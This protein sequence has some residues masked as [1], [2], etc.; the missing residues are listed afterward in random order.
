M[1][2][3]KIDTINKI[4]KALGI[5]YSDEQRK[6]LEQPSNEAML[7]N[8]CAGSGKTTLFITNVLV[9]EIT[10]EQPADSV[11]GITFSRKAREEMEERY[12]KYVKI[13]SKEGLSVTS[14]P[15]FQ[16]F[17]ALFL[18]LLR[19]LPK[20]NMVKVLSSWS[21]YYIELAKSF[22]IDN[23]QTDKTK[24][25]YLDDIFNTY[26]FLINQGFS[27]DGIN[28]NYSLPYIKAIAPDKSY[29]LKKVLPLIDTKQYDDHYIDNYIKVINK[30]QQLKHTDGVIDFND[31]MILLLNELRD[32][33]SYNSLRANMAKYHKCYIDE[34]QDIDALQWI[35]IKN[36]LSEEAM[37]KIF[38][39]GDDDQS[40]YGFRGSS[41]YYITKFATK[42]VPTAKVMNLSTNYRT[43][44][45]ILN[46]AVPMIT[47]NK[48]RLNKSLDA[49]NKDI[50]KISMLE[51]EGD[52]IENPF[53]E[54]ILETIEKAKENHKNIAIL[55][56]Y[57]FDKM[58]I[59]DY[60]ATKEIYVKSSTGLLQDNR[61]YQ[62]I[63]GLM[64]A[65]INNDTVAFIKLSN[66]IG[67]S[68]LK[69]F[70]WSMYYQDPLQGNEGLKDFLDYALEYINKNSTNKK[71]IV[72]RINIE[73][74]LDAIEVCNDERDDYINNH[75]SSEIPKEKQSE[76][77]SLWDCVYAI[78][79]NYYRYMIENNYINGAN[80]NELVAYIEYLS[81]RITT[82]K[83]FTL[84]EQSKINNLKNKNYH[85][86]NISLLTIHQAKGLEFNDVFLYGFTEGD[87]DDAI[88]KLSNTF[89]TNITFT[90]F[91]KEFNAL[92]EQKKLVLLHYLAIM[93]NTDVTLADKTLQAMCPDIKLGKLIKALVKDNYEKQFI[94]KAKV[95]YEVFPLENRDYRILYH[96]LTSLCNAVE[97]ERRILYVSITRAK[98]N[99]YIEYRDDSASPLLK[100][101]KVTMPKKTRKISKA[102]VSE[103]TI[104]SGEAEEAMKE[105]L[106]L[107]YEN[108]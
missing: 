74:I 104:S 50:G 36:L 8:A 71:L 101:L 14:V 34:F 38:V 54:K 55:C 2:N 80:Y 88:L 79:Y 58:L 105:I 69:K 70:L 19:S 85:F 92:A 103:G 21:K 37:S 47:N 95:K 44:E 102:N 20:Y 10:G 99:C 42:L 75:F 18:S 16:T 51:T 96:S 61:M 45:N 60:L 49:F 26:D 91:E 13:L 22:K 87:I 106:N 72:Y 35:I 46:A 5:N 86:N 63:V 64:S 78:T 43:G 82:F 32:P 56:R 62:N 29:D 68:K 90:E 27:Y 97:E 31:M 3:S 98:N 39:V 23:N 53:L 67:F 52:F 65:I 57:N 108:E 30:Y 48:S 33:N 84:A 7:V 93:A 4:S 24:K 107:G 11:L 73:K 66:L 77:Y 100:E 41:S 94:K 28:L 81:R 76:F 17:H 40:I 15:K 1:N 6:V 25:D 83:E 59:R 12:D 9:E 89:S